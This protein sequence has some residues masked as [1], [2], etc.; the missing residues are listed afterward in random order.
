M[1]VGATVNKSSKKFPVVFWAKEG[2]FF[3]F[4]ITGFGWAPSG[5][6]Y[7]FYFCVRQGLA[8]HPRLVLNPSAAAP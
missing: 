1:W 7:A 2:F 8:M 3:S 5:L 6:K 4:Q